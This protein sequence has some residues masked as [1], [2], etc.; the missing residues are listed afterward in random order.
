MRKALPLSKITGIIPPGARLLLHAGP[1]ESVALRDVLRADTDC[2]RGSTIAGLF[3]PGVNTFDYADLTPTTRIETLFVSPALRRSFEAGRVDLL[4]M[5][6]SHYP[7]F[8]AS[9][10]ADLAILHLPPARN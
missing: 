8:L 4:P 6:Y 5:H 10:P 9:R 7:A 2:L 1:A 3:I